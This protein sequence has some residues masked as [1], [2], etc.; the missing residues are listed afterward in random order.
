M[1]FLLMVPRNK[2]IERYIEPEVKFGKWLVES[3]GEKG[4]FDRILVV[5]ICSEKESFP[6]M[7]ES[8]S[9]AASRHSLQVLVVL[10]VN[11]RKEAPHWMQSNNHEFLLEWNRKL[12]GVQVHDT[13]EAFFGF[14]KSLRILVVDR[15]TS[16][17]E[18]PPK[19]GVGLARKI[20]CDIAYY[21]WEAKKSI[22]PFAFTSDGDATL[23]LDYFMG[24][25]WRELEHL[26]VSAV[27]FPFEHV[28]LSSMSQDEVRAMHAYDYYLRYY[29]AG[30][31][32]S[33]SP[34]AYQNIGSTISFSLPFYGKVRGFPKK[35]A[36]ED[37]YFLNKLR[38]LGPIVEKK[39]E[40]IKLQGRPSTRVPFGTGKSIIN[41]ASELSKGGDYHVYHPY[42]FEVLKVL[43][44][45]TD[46]YC[47]HLNYQEFLKGCHVALEK[48]K[49]ACCDFQYFKIEHLEQIISDM[50]LKDFLL[51]K[52]DAHQNFV[53]KKYQFMVWF[54]SFKTLKFVHELRYHFFPSVPINAAVEL[55]SPNLL[56]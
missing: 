10:V 38:K 29:Q 18:F 25:N 37:F 21:L 19:Q 53:Q 30:L 50:G 45:Q 35:E 47:L 33:G 5:P 55:Y 1:G 42:V 48:K 16:G 6:T 4:A 46:L 8:V 43:I 7:V 44:E 3:V 20:G 15:A 26:K 51:N 54:D 34:Y 36:G 40:P 56:G 28:E 17:R 14:Y 31:K 27:T 9:K 13:E 39:G 24:F 22:A 23:P 41:I 52:F 11:H 49:L 2:Y 12:Q 32:V